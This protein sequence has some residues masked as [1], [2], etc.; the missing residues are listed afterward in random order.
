MKKSIVVSVISVLAVLTILFGVLYITNNADKT[1]QIEALN[2]HLASKDEKI[3]DLFSTLSEKNEQIEVLSSDLVDRENKIETLNSNITEKAN[4]IENLT[5]DITVKANQIEN[6]NSEISSKDKQIVKLTADIAEKTDQIKLLKS[7]VTDKAGK[8]ESLEGDIKIISEQDEKN[9]AEIEKKDKEIEILNAQA[10]ADAE[11]IEGLEDN[12]SALNAQLKTLTANGDQ[13][14]ATGEKKDN[15]RITQYSIANKLKILNTGHFTVSVPEQWLTREENNWYYYYAVHTSKVQGG[16]LAVTE[17]D[18]ALDYASSGDDVIHEILSEFAEGVIGEKEGQ[19][20][21]TTINGMSAVTIRHPVSDIMF[22]NTV[23]VFDSGYLLVV[24]YADDTYD[25]IESFNVAKEYF[26]T[27]KTLSNSIPSQTDTSIQTYPKK[28]SSSLKEY[29]K[30]LPEVCY[31]TPASE[32][33]Y[34]GFPCYVIGKVVRLYEDDEVIESIPAMIQLDTEK[35]PI[36]FMVFSP[37][38]ML[39]HDTAGTIKTETDKQIFYNLFDITMDY[40]LPAI[41][42]EVCIYGVYSGFSGRFNMAIG[43]FGLDDYIYKQQF[44]T[45]TPSKFEK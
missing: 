31:T 28:F 29:A 43:Y 42:E 26:T 9:K 20:E 34:S 11:K 13:N 23:I 7:D 41:G 10:K 4:Q 15:E 38:Y 5:A 21:F 6:L 3:E 45:Y 44:G 2:T 33:G 37:D 35:G 27:I 16:Y 17:L 22:A 14:N 25:S 40:T 12:I 30:P 39:K 24:S 36:L 1:K 8:I 32:N 18:V 19:T